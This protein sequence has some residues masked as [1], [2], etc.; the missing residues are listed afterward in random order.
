MRN[1]AIPNTGARPRLEM[2]SRQL[3]ILSRSQEGVHKLPR[4]LQ[5][6]IDHPMVE[7]SR[8][9][10][11]YEEVRIIGKGDGLSGAARKSERQSGDHQAQAQCRLEGCLLEGAHERRSL[12]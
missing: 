7:L 6:Y 12:G 2:S 3:D 9:R 8:Y 10:R 4:V 5:P 1:L 11:D